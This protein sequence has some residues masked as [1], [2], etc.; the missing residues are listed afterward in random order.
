ML[1][2]EQIAFFRHKGFVLLRG[3]FGPAEVGRLADWLERLRQAPPAPGRETKYYERSPVTGANLLV[4]AEFLLGEHNAEIEKL[5]LNARTLQC[6][7][8]LLDEP[9]LL[10][11]EKVNYKLPGCRP[12]KLH[13][14][15]AAGWNAYGKFFITMAIMVD[16]NTRENA[17][18][19]IMKSGNYQHHLMG[20]EWQPLSEADPPYQPEDE[21]LLLEG[22][23]GDVVFFDCYVPHGSPANTSDR[24]RRNIYLTFNRRSDGDMRQRY[25][26][27]KWRSYPPNTATDARPDS[28]YRV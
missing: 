17:A 23:P 6:L 16:P 2:T 19:S 4:R 25:Y 18:L 21:Y 7:T 3:F 10:F 27:D 22:E 5:L 15:Q 13:Q 28:A 14:D 11:K 8:E 12:D 26:A 24:P 1:T 9:P 20:P